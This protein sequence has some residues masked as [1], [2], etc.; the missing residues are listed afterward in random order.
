[1]RTG[2]AKRQLAK[3]LVLLALVVPAVADEDKWIEIP[4]CRLIVHAA[5]DGDSFHVR[6]DG[7]EYLAR[8]Y[9]VDAPEYSRQIPERVREQA[10]WFGTTEENVLRHGELA[11]ARVTEWLDRPFTLYTQ[12][13][14]ARGASSMQRVFAMV[15]VDDRYLCELLVENGLARIHGIRRNLHDG[16]FRWD[17]VRKLESL[18]KKAKAAK[19]GLWGD[20]KASPVVK[21]LRRVTLTRDVPFYTAGALPTFRGT[22][23]KGD[24]VEILSDAP[25]LV[26]VRAPFRGKT[27]HGNCRR[28]DLVGQ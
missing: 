18:E 14:D 2:F 20:G 22:L 10:D 27:E 9:F 11:A 25:L 6:G 1:M 15:K 16:T 21:V 5:N 13:I 19:V 3:V 7:R 23:K 8:L 24:I 4:D 28:Q 26:A 17:H 12:M